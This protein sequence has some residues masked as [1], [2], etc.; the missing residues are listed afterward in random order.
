MD[1]RTDAHVFVCDPGLASGVAIFHVEKR[2]LISVESYEETQNDLWARVYDSYTD[3]VCE[4]FIIGT[5]TGKKSQAPWSLE[6]IGFMRY[7]A[8]RQQA[9]FE[10]Q[11]PADAKMVFPN[12]KLKDHGLWHRGGAGHAMDALRHGALYIAKRWGYDVLRTFKESP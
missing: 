1:L 7:V 3:I 10:L 9:R 4:R 5:N 2:K 12:Q 11:A 8:W 6:L